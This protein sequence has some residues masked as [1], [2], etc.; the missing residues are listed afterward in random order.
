[1][2]G[3]TRKD[4]ALLDT[5]LT[6]TTTFTEPAARVLGTGATIAPSLQLDGVEATPPNITVPGWLPN[7]DPLIVTDPPT[8]LTGPAVGER[9]VMLGPDCANAREENSEAAR[10]PQRSITRVIM[11]QPRS[12]A[13]LDLNNKTLKQASTYSL[14]YNG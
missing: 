10:K 6:V 5:P 7:P 4:W 14:G 1:M 2:T 13:V 9:L 11:A 8:G 12:W 3:M